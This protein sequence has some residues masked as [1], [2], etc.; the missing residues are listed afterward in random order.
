[1]YFSN[2]GFNKFSKELKKD[3]EL[4]KHSHNDDNEFLVFRYLKGFPAY[5]IDSFFDR[6]S[7][8]DLKEFFIY[9]DVSNL[10]RN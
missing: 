8:D 4:V 1:M 7:E 3:L 9:P 10:R 2:E 5:A 6:F